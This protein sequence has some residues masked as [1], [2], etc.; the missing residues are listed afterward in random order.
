VATAERVGSLATGAQ[1]GVG[2]AHRDST[3]AAF[4]DRVDFEDDIVIDLRPEVSFRGHPT[5]VPTTYVNVVKPVLDRTLALMLCALA[6]PVL[7]VLIPA[8]W[9]SMGRPAIFTQPRVGKDGK[10]FTVY[11][12]RTMK[13]DRRAG[14]RPFSGPDRRKVHKS[15]DDP[16]ITAV[17]RIL[18][19]WSLDEIPQLFNVLLGQMSLVGP[20]PELVEIVG[21]KYDDWQ[22]ERHRVKPG[23]TGLWQIS[24]QRQELMYEATHVDLEYLDRVSLREDLR[25]LVLTIPA[26]IGKRN[27]Y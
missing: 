2:V 12:L 24:E 20:R 6:L 18:R 11:K 1:T 13:H 25:I 26:A 14:Q 19:E 5:F 22:H 15:P 21:T 23:L 27:G 10:P 3:D 8:I 16:R 9:M 4:S 17:G 7:L